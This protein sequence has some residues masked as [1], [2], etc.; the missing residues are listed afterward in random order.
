MPTT[1]SPTHVAIAGGGVAAVEL[2]LALHALAGA[3]VRVTLVAPQPD[4]E[5]R[6]LRTAEPFWPTTPAATRWPIW[7]SASAR[8]SSPIASWPST[9][10]TTVRLASPGSGYDTLVLATG[11]RRR[12]AYSV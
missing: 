5:L 2:A 11:A 1:E 7:L 8:G 9:P 12:T 10:T 3:R 6:A 4:F